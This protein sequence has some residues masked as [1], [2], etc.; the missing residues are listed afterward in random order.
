MKGVKL[1]DTTL[2]DGAQGEGVSFSL[3]DKLRIAR[4]LSELGVHYIEGGWPGANP[5]DTELFARARDLDLGEAKLVAFGSTRRAGLPPEKDPC[6]SALLAAGTPAVAVVGKSWTLHVDQVLRTSRKENL[7]MIADSVAFLKEREKE[8]IFDAEHFF[9]GFFEDP[10]YALATLERAADAGAD[11]LVLCDTNGGTLPWQVEKVVRE[12]RREFPHVP[13]GIHA[14][15]DCEL[16]VANTLVA[17]RA[18]VSLVQGTVNGYGERCGNAN[19][20]SVIPNLQLKLGLEVLPKEKLRELT[21]LSYFVAELANLAPS[22]YQPY[23]GRAAFAHKGGIHVDALAK[24]PRSY[25]HIDPELVGNSD[26]VLV[27]ELSGR[28]NILVKARELGETLSREEAA[29]LLEEVKA[30]EK[31][32]FQFEAAEGSLSLLIRRA[33][34]DWRPPFELLDFLVLVE[35]RTGKEILSEATVKVRVG[36]EVIHTAAEGNGPVNALDRAIRKAL[37]PFWPQLSHVRLTDYKVRILNGQAGTEATVR[38]LI[39]ASDGRR[40]WATVG[41]SPNIIEASWQALADSLE[42]PLV[43]D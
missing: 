38:V 15:N 36:D 9:D 26:R 21:H 20:C 2:R 12:V 16:A 22:P 19:L 6:L 17:V 23:V 11:W 13:L 27:S 24:A 29:R 14:H 31:K 7:R 30:L 42:F 28:T 40:Q 43:N 39:V 18:G 37:I 3:A 34:P 41:S 32:G 33:R 5:K 1:Y 35:K 25:R 8:V 4:R 10:E